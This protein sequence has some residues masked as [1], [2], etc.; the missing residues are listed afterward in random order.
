MVR[1]RRLLS[2]KVISLAAVLAVNLSLTPGAA[3]D[4]D[5]VL[6]APASEF[7]GRLAPTEA[8]TRGTYSVAPPRAPDDA[9][10]ILLVMTDDVGFGAASTFGGPVPTP[11][12]DRLAAKG[13]RYNRFHTTGICSPTRAALLTGRNHHNVGVG[14]VT[15]MASPYPGYVGEISPAAAGIARILRDHG[16]STAMF[17]K[18]HNVPSDERSPAGPFNN[19]PTGR[20]FEYFYGFIGGDTNQ[21]QPGLVENITQVE[22]RG[23]GENI[24]LDRELADRAINWIHN[25]KA[26]APDKPFF[27]YY[28]PGSGH[29]P[30][31]APADWIARFR[32]QFDDGWDALRQRTFARQKAEGIIP[33]ESQL[34]ARPD[35]VPAWNSLTD[36]ER[37]VYARF[38]EVFA[39]QLAY[40]D[41]QFGRL[42][43]ELERMGIADDTLVVFIQGDNGA[44]GDGALE[45]TVNEIADLSSPKEHAIDIDWLADH[46]D[47]LGGPDTYQTYTVGWT[48]ALS[49]PFPWFKQLAS[50]LGGVRNGLV[51][52]WPGQIDTGGEMRRQYHHVIDVAP[53]L[54]EVAG[55]PAPR[56]VD[57]IE[58]LPM[59]GMSMAYSFASPKA[60]SPR[61]TQYYEISANRAIYHN[62][63]LA[64]ST[65]EVM[66]WD[67]VSKGGDKVVTGY[68]WELYNLQSD[69]AQA[70]NLAATY[71]GKLRELQKIF[72]REAR[73]Y[74]VYPLQNTSAIARSLR[75]RALH[76][77]PFRSR[78]EYW[79]PGIQLSMAA[80][81]PIFYLPFSVEAEIE[82]GAEGGRGVIIAAGSDFSGW[83]FY[84]DNG[85]P[86]AYASVSPLQGRQYKVA[87]DKS[88][89]AGRHQVR[90]EFAPHKA[91]GTVKIVV[92]GEEW[93]T[94]SVAERPHVLAGNGETFDTGRDSRGAVSPDYDSEGVFNGTLSKVTVE[95]VAPQ[96]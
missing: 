62:G 13:L 35:I 48:Y 30:H 50:H 14:S 17:G 53:T 22:S 43:A 28:A 90:Y 12:L 38:M 23:R 16:Y 86:V 75:M 44:S 96:R 69:F 73:K 49:T 88:L 85:R 15:E 7:Q 57:G 5:S 72:D 87:S 9:P 45:G 27:I 18:D 4:A 52:A 60:P 92:N 51:V 94:G 63:W 33:A 79:G 64:N 84:L 32:G 41:A 6:P 10:N 3:A 20:G 76:P 55:I 34:P 71:P 67:G 47:V 2:V 1:A 29:A 89:P 77:A 8:G 80:A 74:N 61:H 37:K 26:A 24:L 65:P 95:V 11:N 68:R 40:Q 36:N 91:G 42:M 93:A 54:L 39:A 46:L 19:W 56:K 25:Q 81:P 21:W 31:Q 66:P 78:Y 82:V 59:D 70:N 58:Q 83:S